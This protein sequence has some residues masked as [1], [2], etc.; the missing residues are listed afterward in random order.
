MKRKISWTIAGS[1]AGGFSGIQ[2]DLK[3]FQQL[4]VHGASVITAITSQNAREINDIHFLAEDRLLSQINSL[5]QNIFPDSIKIG[6]LGN[7]STIKIVM[8][9]LQ[10]FSGPVILDPLLISSSDK[11]LYEGEESDYLMQLKNLFQLISLITPNVNE[12]EKIVNFRINSH[13][14]IEK[15]AQV[16]LSFG[17]KSVLIKGG[18]FKND[19]WS[20]DYWTNGVEAFWIS[21]ERHLNRNCRGT[22]CALSSAIAA[23]LALAYEIKDAIVI[24]KM[25]VN[26]GIRL[27]YPLLDDVSLFH[28]S[29]WPEEPCDLPMLS[30]RPIQNYSGKFNSVESIGLYPI[31]DSIAWLEKLLPLGV[32]TLQLRIKN[33]SGSELEKEIRESIALANRHEAKLFINDFWELAIHHGAYGV[34]L[35]QGDL[36][37]A[38]IEKIR[39]AGLHLGVSTHCY[40]EVARAHALSPS[41]IAC[42]PIFPTTSKMMPFAPQG[43]EQLKRWR[44]TL[45]YPLIAIGGIDSEKLTSILDTNVNGIAMISA[46]TQSENP[47]ETT[48]KLLNRVSDHVNNTRR[49]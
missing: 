36:K 6:M 28:H 17:A 9:F 27:S 32:K 19:E 24:A 14:D 26:R 31:V 7:R 23:F 11:R 47:I 8:D 39:R 13:G 45:Q 21:N 1:D 30:D 43:I 10:S 48:K 35:G 37:N 38:N 44:R 2:N 34:H 46:I 4:G 15:A 40:Y 49:N 41:Y 16:I 33:K 20:Q 18:H 29:G 5:R 42:G 22:G 25:Y 12:A 3:T